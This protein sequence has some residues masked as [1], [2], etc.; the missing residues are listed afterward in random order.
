MQ[1]KIFKFMGG[2]FEY[3]SADNV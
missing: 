2:A 1:E 3:L